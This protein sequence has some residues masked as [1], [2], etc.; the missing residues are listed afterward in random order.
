M[1]FVC[2]RY[3]VDNLSDEDKNK[4]ILFNDDTLVTCY[5]RVLVRGKEMY[6]IPRYY[7]PSME[8]EDK[9]TDGEDIDIELNPDFVPLDEKQERAIHSI[10]THD[11]GLISARVGFGKTYV[12]VN[13]ITKIKKRTLVIVHVSTKDGLMDQ[14]K[15]SFL[16]YTNLK[17]EDI[18]YLTS[19]TKTIDK[20]IYLTTVQTLIS[21]VKREDKAFM[22]MMYK[23]NFGCAFYDE[24]HIT[25]SSKE[26]SEATKII[27]SKRIYGLSATLVRK[28]G[29]API[30]FW[31]IG[32]I[33][34]DDNVWFVLPLNVGLL[35]IPINLK[36]Y[37]KYL[38]M[39]NQSAWSSKYGVFLSKQE[40]Y[41]QTI[42]KII[43]ISMENGR[44]PL[45]LSSQIQILNKIYEKCS[46]KDQISIVHGKVENKDY[47]KRCILATLGMFKVGMDVPRLDT[48]IF[49]TPLTAKNGLIQAIG[50]VAR[51]CKS[52]PNKKVV[53]LDITNSLYSKTMD[54][55]RIRIGYYKE[56][57]E[58]ST[59]G[60]N[61]IDLENVDNVAKF[62]QKIVK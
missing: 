10:V 41:I 48:L 34:Y 14:W 59:K 37:A 50:R 23:G 55:R 25:A 7:F 1:S 42:A 9:R 57:D 36:G 16:K 39:G 29:L 45:I 32:D 19:K 3:Y 43:D 35:D 60:C 24:C 58:K 62:F 30:L 12:A 17:E 6:R 18:G 49:A 61:I 2:D 8:G 51:V 38:S 52:N 13:A 27:Y 40:N 44:N 47:D 5:D 26:F 53:I 15:E 21:R 46:Y 54:M 56:L 4:L 11:H 28:D 20:P 33:I 31:N 22:K